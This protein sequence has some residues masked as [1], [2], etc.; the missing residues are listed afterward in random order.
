MQIIAE[1]TQS[2]TNSQQCFKKD[3]SEKLINVNSF[4][5]LGA[6]VPDE[7]TKPELQKY[8]AYSSICIA[9]NNKERQM[10][11]PRK[12]NQTETLPGHAT[13]IYASEYW[14]LSTELKRSILATE[15]RR[16]RRSHHITYK[17]SIP[18][19]EIGDTSNTAI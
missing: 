19:N 13:F 2:M 7:G 6:N 4:K 5:Y 18:N 11:S 15:L 1:K 10:H 17:D 9:S 16:Y 3:I 14:K 8:T 12:Y